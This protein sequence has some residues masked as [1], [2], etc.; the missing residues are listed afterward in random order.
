MAHARTHS[1]PRSRSLRRM[2]ARLLWRCPRRHDR[3]ADRQLP[4]LRIRGAGLVDSIQA[5]IR[6]SKPMARPRPSTRRAP[7]SRKLGRCSC[8]TE[9]RLISGNGA[10][11]KPSPH[12]NIACGTPVIGSRRSR[13][14]AG[15][16]AFA[17]PASRSAA[18]PTTSI[19]HIWK[20]PDEIRR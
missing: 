13:R 11:S 10:R 16:P 18:C 1:P 12:K 6:E 9:P 8:R 7:S 14:T 17:A 5:V 3:Q 20:R 19:P 2:L 4:L 15:Q